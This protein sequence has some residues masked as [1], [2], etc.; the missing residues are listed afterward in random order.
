[1]KA[2]A[3]LLRPFVRPY[4]RTLLVAFAAMAGEVGAAILGPVP[5]QRIVD[6]VV[7]AGKVTARPGVQLQIS[8]TTI[9]QVGLL[10]GAYVA[11]ALLN[12]LCTYADVRSTARVALRTSTDLRRALF[13]H[14]QRLSLS[15]HHDRDTRL[16]ELQTRLSADVS[17]VQDLIASQLSVAVTNTGTAALMITLLTVLDRRLGLIVLTASFPLYF[18]ARHYRGRVRQ[19]VKE[20]RRQEGRV[21][22]LLSET[23]SV[24]RLVQVLGREDHELD[25][26]RSATAH[27]LNYNLRAA[28]LQARVDPLLMVSTYFLT[29]LVLLVAAVLALQH[30]LSVGQLTLVLSYTR[31][32]YGAIRSLAKMPVQAQKGIV[33]AERLAELFARE[34]GVREPA[35]PQALKFGPAGVSFEDVTFGYVADRPVLRGITWRVPPG[36]TVALVGATGSGKS[37]MLSLI[38]RLYD[39]WSGTVRLGG[40]DVSQVRLAELRGQVSLVLQ[41][42]LLFRDTVYNNIAYGR[43]DASDAEILAAAEVAGV[44]TFTEELED[45]LDTII[46]ERGSTLSG[47]QKQ[48]VAIARA[49]LRDAPVVLMDEPT[50]NLDAATEKLVVDGMRNLVA[51]RTSIIIAHRFTTIR[52][53]DLVAVLQ[54]GRLVQYGTPDQ[55][56]KERGLFASLAKMQGVRL[57]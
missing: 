47:G 16:G 43:P 21:T 42:S 8:A 45:G 15:F 2:A 46:S 31:G 22:A 29:A 1:M 53:A 18:I 37:T 41:E 50:S 11:I 7:K 32:T 44:L 6:I 56:M 14:V 57:K 4:V 25:R 36:A 5:F 20:A 19:A 48:C 26:V 51:G 12:G 24:A 17:N 34:T 54:D 9:E 49:F 13:D 10:A 35:H 27:G 33:A 3:G 52:H 55:L 40:V 30:T 38:P 23:L 39:P 28:D